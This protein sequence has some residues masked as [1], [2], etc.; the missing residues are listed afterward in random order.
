L[1]AD[2]I[3]GFEAPRLANVLPADDLA[4]LLDLLL[5]SIFAALLAAALLGF[6]DDANLSTSSIIYYLDIIKLNCLILM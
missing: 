1:G 6:F 4:D 5:L 2:F 3:L